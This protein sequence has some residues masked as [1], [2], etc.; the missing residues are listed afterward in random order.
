ME[1]SRIISEKKLKTLPEKNVIGIDIGSRQS[2]A[3]LLTKDRQIYTTI[4]P[5][6]FF[7]KQVAAELISDLFGQSGLK[8]ENIDF[9]VCTGYGRIA[10]DFEDVPSRIVTEISCH[11]MGAHYLGENIHTIIDIGG[12][13]SKAIKID[14]ENGK[15]IDFVMNDKCAAGT[16]RFLEKAAGILGFGVEELGKASLKSE[17]PINI[18]STCVVFAESEIISVRAKNDNVPDI[19]AGIHKSV[20][21]R[22]SSLLA[23][24][25]IEK[26]VLFTGGVS[27]NVGM[28]KA[29]EN[30]LGFSIEN[31][32]LDTVFAGALGAAVYAGQYAEKQLKTVTGKETDIKLDLSDLE[33]AI[34]KKKELFSNRATGKKKN[35]AYFC[36]YAPVEIL[37]AANVSYIRMMHAGTQQELASGEKYT[38][39]II[40]DFTKGT[41]GSFFEN[42][43][44]Y[45]G[46]DKVYA[47]NTCRCIK[48]MVEAINE[49]FVPA[50]LYNLP[51]N[52]AD[53]IQVDYLASEFKAFRKDLE[54]LTKEKITDEAIA[55]QVKLYNIAR[56]Y[57]RQISDYRKQDGLLIS[58]AQFQLIVR[59]Y[60]YL[61]VEELLNELKK[62]LKQLEKIKPDNNRPV[63]IMV[64]GGIM[65][66]GDNK[67]IDILE[68]TTDARVVIEDNCTGYTPVSFDVELNS[69]DVFSNLASAYLGK[70]PCTRMGS[71]TERADFSAN[72][73]KE[74]KVDGILYYYLKFCPC[75]G[76]PQSVFLN[77]YKELGIPVLQ[78][79]SDYSANDEGQIRTRIEAFMEVLDERD[80]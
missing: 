23:R 33:S 78:I 60:F 58:T 26:N 16:G 72:L 65:A 34:E 45:S 37:G 38:K 50:T 76:V 39:S 64:A 57:I 63:R 62:I 74:Y 69:E 27:N 10:L 35:V 21:K 7:M 22:V 29:F 36:S 32:E 17:N 56:R 68:K 59:A 2:K 79:P 47:F 1:L 25:G 53:E 8:I 4:I 15:V 24:V 18:S 3:V 70:A 51:V 12:Q 43:P 40:C 55:E 61:D 5:T 13:D 77:K 28:R 11:G 71:L 42:N 31:A 6:G 41:M 54:Q 30:L 67:I 75:F 80:K 52:I 46:I 14:P 9:I 49:N 66:D 19:A 44:L 20:A 48:T 73:A